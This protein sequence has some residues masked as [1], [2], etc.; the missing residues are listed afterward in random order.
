[1]R[2]IFFDTFGWLLDIDRVTERKHEAVSPLEITTTV[3]SVYYYFVCVVMGMFRGLSLSAIS[4]A[5]L[6]YS[7]RR[8]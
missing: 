3:H 5:L 4:F 8:G 6:A 1:M 7:S 2:E